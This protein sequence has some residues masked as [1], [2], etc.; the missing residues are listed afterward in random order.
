M[1]TEERGH[2]RT[3]REGEASREHVGTERGKERPGVWSSPLYAPG[4]W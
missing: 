2:R 4:G 1:R 3:E